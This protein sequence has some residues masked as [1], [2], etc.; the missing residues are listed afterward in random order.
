MLID[1]RHLVQLS[2]IIETGSFQA[3]ADKLGLSQPALSRNI[4][5]LEQRI[6]APVFDRSARNAVPTN[7]G[8][9]L[10]QNG[11]TIR[12]AESEAGHFSELVSTGMAGE[13]RIGAPPIISGEFLTKHISSFISKRPNCKIDLRVGLIHELKTMLERSQIDL[14]VGPQD[15]TI[16]TSNLEFHALIDDNVGILSKA[17]HP[18]QSV[19]NLTYKH[20]QDYRWAAHSRNSMLRQQTENALVAMGMSKIDIA[21]ET[22]SIQSVLELVAST[23]LITTMPK[24]TSKP[25]LTDDL[26]FLNI[27]HPQFYRPIGAIYSK[28]APENIVVGEFL[29]QLMTQ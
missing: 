26:K 6:K 4:K 18:L 22:D 29:N 24:E 5:I 2:V 14:V 1:P 11:L 23:E 3:A 12:N 16:G 17:D 25:Y 15:L 13:V 20:L 27:D 9:K 10:A 8:L 7:L 21:F 19:K 28:Y